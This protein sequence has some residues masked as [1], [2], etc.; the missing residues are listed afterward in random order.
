VIARASSHLTISNVYAKSGFFANAHGLEI[1]TS[2]I[3]Y[4]HAS[5]DI[6]LPYHQVNHLKVM[7]N[8]SVP[9]P[10]FRFFASLKM[11]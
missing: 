10:L 7:S 11:Q 5:G 9:P 8:T 6:D 2:S 4:D 3:D 1:R